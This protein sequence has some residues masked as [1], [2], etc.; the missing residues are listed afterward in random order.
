MG[1]DLK[2]KVKATDDSNLP[3]WDY[4]EINGITYE[5]C[6]TSPVSE[7]SLLCSNCNL[8]NCDHVF[9][10][11]LHRTESKLLWE[12]LSRFGDAVWI[13]NIPIY[14][15]LKPY[16]V[17]VSPISSKHLSTVEFAE[18][19]WEWPWGPSELWHVWDGAIT[20]DSGSVVLSR[21]ESL[22]DIR[23][24]ILRPFKALPTPKTCSSS[25]HGFRNESICK[26]VYENRSNPDRLAFLYCYY[27]TKT[28]LPCY[29]DMNS[30]LNDPRLIPGSKDPF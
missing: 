2:L 7:A 20:P 30:A 1:R 11:M 27:T 6:F 4:V 5:I 9:Y 23:R 28:C 22:L 15:E 19:T 29:R 18:V 3:R 13:L 12:R 26:Q 8:V 21:G 25:S 16:R 24:A 10:S 14:Q 17:A